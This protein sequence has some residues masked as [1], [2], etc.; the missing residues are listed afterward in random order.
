MLSSLVSELLQAPQAG[1]SVQ[2]KKRCLNLNSEYRY[3]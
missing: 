1:L 3:R 2:R